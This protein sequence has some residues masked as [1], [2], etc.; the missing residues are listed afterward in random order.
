MD[1]ISVTFAKTD[2]CDYAETARLQ[3]FSV[4][5]FSPIGL[6]EKVGRVRCIGWSMLE[7]DSENGHL[8][9]RNNGCTTALAVLFSE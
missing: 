2:T 6:L 7:S 4:C 5:N 8:A 1:R 9:T 3:I